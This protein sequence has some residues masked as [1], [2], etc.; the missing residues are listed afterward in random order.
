[1]PPPPLG[2]REP[3]AKGYPY[4]QNPVSEGPPVLRRQ[5]PRHGAMWNNTA[6]VL[7]TSRRALRSGGRSSPGSR[8]GPRGTCPASLL[9]ARRNDRRFESP[10][11]RGIASTAVAPPGGDRGRKRGPGPLG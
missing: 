2:G 10:R 5:E 6:P 9:A 1:M 7:R 8:P 3:H 4:A 11:A